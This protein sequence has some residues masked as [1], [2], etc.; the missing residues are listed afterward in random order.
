[1]NILMQNSYLIFEP[2][3]AQRY[4]ATGAINYNMYNFKQWFRLKRKTLINNLIA[5]LK[6]LF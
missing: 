2:R 1:M 6:Y 4:D 3:Q 5:V